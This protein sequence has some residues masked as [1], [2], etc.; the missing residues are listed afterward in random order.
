MLKNFNEEF[1][2]LIEWDAAKYKNLNG[3]ST[4]F[5]IPGKGAWKTFDPFTH[6]HGYFTSLLHFLH[7]QSIWW[8]R[9]EGI[10]LQWQH[11]HLHLNVNS[12]ETTILHVGMR[13]SSTEQG[14]YKETRNVVNLLQQ[15]RPNLGLKTANL[16]HTNSFPPLLKGSYYVLMQAFK[17][18]CLKS[19][20]SFPAASWCVGEQEWGWSPGSPLMGCSCMGQ[21]SSTEGA[22]WNAHVHWPTTKE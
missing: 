8:Q 10:K 11:H 12:T 17:D 19:P 7:P 22:A 6:H 1:D 18:I 20:I 14:R 4:H 15:L 16:E 2:R 5:T 13:Y 21:V 3:C 9:K